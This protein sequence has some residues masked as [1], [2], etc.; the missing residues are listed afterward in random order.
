MVPNQARYQATLR[1]EKTQ[2]RRGHLT[3]ACASRRGEPDSPWRPLNSKPV[4]TTEEVYHKLILSATKLEVVVITEILHTF[5][6]HGPNDLAP[7]PPSVPD[8][9][10]P[11]GGR[12]AGS[13]SGWPRAGT[14]RSMAAVLPAPL[15]GLS[16]RGFCPD[17]FTREIRAR[18]SRDFFASDFVWTSSFLPLSPSFRSL[19]FLLDTA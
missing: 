11:T 13:H 19:L 9:K 14:V 18:I 12:G 6:R 17:K 2:R 16:R 8:R 7:V 1:P 5:R 3:A 4:P 15:P 10:P